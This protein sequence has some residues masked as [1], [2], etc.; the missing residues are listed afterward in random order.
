MGNQ[1]TAVIV[2][3]AKEAISEKNQIVTVF[4]ER[5]ASNLDI[6]SFIWLGNLSLVSV[7]VIIATFTLVGVFWGSRKYD[8]YTE[9]RAETNER[10]NE[11]IDK[12]VR[13]VTR[14]EFRKL[15]SE[16]NKQDDADWNPESKGEK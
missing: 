6:S 5:A 14:S 11:R 15:K 12:E 13:K 9:W 16:G 2:E 10:I 1:T 3:S 4:V 8:D 7:S